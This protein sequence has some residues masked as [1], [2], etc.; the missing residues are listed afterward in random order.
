[1]A[2]SAKLGRISRVT[3]SYTAAHVDPIAFNPGD[4]IRL[5]ERDT[6]WPEFVWC[7]NAE[8][9]SGWVPEAAFERHGATGIASRTYS[10]SELRVDTGEIVTIGEEIGGWSCCTN[11]RGESGWVPDTHLAK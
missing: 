1:M 9:K 7:T 4:V 2:V 6:E 10:A 5:G 11:E 8:G 3:A